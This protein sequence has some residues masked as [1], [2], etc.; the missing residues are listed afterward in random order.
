M[1]ERRMSMFPVTMAETMKTP[2]MSDKNCATLNCKRENQDESHL[3]QKPNEHKIIS[4]RFPAQPLLLS[5]VFAYRRVSL[6]QIQKPAAALKSDIFPR[7][8]PF[9]L[10]S[11]HF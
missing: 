4:F 7:K 2:V 9:L 8:K 11:P 1:L 6:S 3:F 5:R 10:L